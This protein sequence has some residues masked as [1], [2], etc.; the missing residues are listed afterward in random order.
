[1]KDW[2][3]SVKQTQTGDAC[4]HD[5]D[6]DQMLDP[7]IRVQLLPRMRAQVTVGLEGTFM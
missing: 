3:V 6:N 1:M 7:G 4:I 2:A 5:I